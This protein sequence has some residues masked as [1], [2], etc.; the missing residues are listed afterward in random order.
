MPLFFFDVRDDQEIIDDVGS[1]FPNVH[2][3]RAAAIKLLPDLARDCKDVANGHEISVT[4]RNEVGEYIFMA[5][6]TLNA[7]WLGGSA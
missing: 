2:A 5:S 4:M 7:K 6:L 3:A 1:E